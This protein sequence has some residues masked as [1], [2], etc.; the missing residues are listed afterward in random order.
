[1]CVWYMCV[2]V[3]TFGDDKLR[4]SLIIHTSPFHKRITQHTH[5]LTQTNTTNDK[6]KQTQLILGGMV[7][8]VACDLLMLGGET[9]PVWRYG[10]C[11]L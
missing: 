9:F 2:C 10:R 5:S 4:F 3:R 6:H 1:M 7:L 8:M 11:A